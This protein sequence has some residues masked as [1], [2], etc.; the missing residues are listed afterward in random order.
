[1]RSLIATVALFGSLAASIAWGQTQT[2]SQTQPQDQAPAPGGSQP[3][4][5]IFS[6]RGA[7]DAPSP[8]GYSSS[9][10]KKVFP[11]AAALP[12][13]TPVDELK[14]PAIELPNDPIEPWLLTR[15]AGPF[16][17]LAKTFRGPDSQKLALA[18]A[19]EL[20][21]KY[22]LPAYVLRSKDF[23]G[24]SNIRGVP[25]TADPG[26][27]QANIN[28]P[29]K[30][31]TY[32]EAAVLVG[33]EKTQAG[34]IALLH[35]VKKI[36]PDC[37]NAM[38]R[39]FHWREG[40]STAL[41]TTNP[42]VAAQYLYPHK[43][44]KL[45]VQMNQ[46]ARSIANCPGRY[47]LQVA[48]FSGRSTFN[49]RDERFQGL[50]SLKKSPLATAAADAERLAAKLAKDPDIQRLGQP[51]YVYHDRRSSRVFIGSFNAEKDPAAVET[52]DA[53]VRLAVDLMKNDR[54][55][56]GVD[57]MIVPAGMLT[58]LKDIKANFQ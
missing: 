52:R 39:M 20:R 1:M 3:R 51:I 36:K 26:V 53:L 54:P 12:E 42:Y 10:D 22:N 23:P 5:P 43:P 40:L 46:T 55:T 15:D 19:K 37:L 8:G 27:V 45:I 17:V 31:R 25:P 11:S 48:E 29:E 21:T 6:T 2:Q 28:V 56:G 35:Q 9:K 33:N 44:D 49:E 13:P 30:Y 7:Q 34:A 58:N 47:S 57:T 41:R 14:P 16:M 32:D 38:P 24:K 18:L 4:S 50:A